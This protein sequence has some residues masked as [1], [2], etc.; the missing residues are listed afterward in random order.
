MSVGYVRPVLM[1]ESDGQRRHKEARARRNET[2]SDFL[3][4][5]AWKKKKKKKREQGPRGVRRTQKKRG[6][7]GGQLPSKSTRQV[8]LEILLS[9]LLV[10]RCSAW[11][12]LAA[13]VMMLVVWP[14]PTSQT[15][16]S[17]IVN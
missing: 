9:L 16:S 10:C 14:D 5:K 15:V 13:A 2:R 17:Y 3:P 8:S 1:S 4:D 12:Y 7:V 6:D 11:L